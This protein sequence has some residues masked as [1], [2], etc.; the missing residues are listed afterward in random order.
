MSPRHPRK[1]PLRRP[2]QYRLGLRVPVPPPKLEKNLPHLVFYEGKWHLFR[3]RWKSQFRGPQLY[4]ASI[5]ANTIPE[6]KQRLAKDP[7]RH[8]F[9][10]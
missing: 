3:S 2:Y 8:R 6:V 5:S 4:A 7:D 1:R 9:G 10:G